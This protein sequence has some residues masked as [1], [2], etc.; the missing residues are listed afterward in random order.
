MTHDDAFL[1]AIIENPEDD[2]PRLVYADWLED[3]G[4]SDRADFIRLQCELARLPGGDPRRK[5]LEARERA[6]LKGHELEWLGPLRG[7]A[8]KWQFRRGFVESVKLGAEEFVDH[9]E[10]ILA[11]APVRHAEFRQGWYDSATVLARLGTCPHLTRLKSIRLSFGV[12]EVSDPGLRALASSPPLLNRLDRLFAMECNVT[13]AG[14]GPVLL[15]PHLGRLRGL[16]LSECR[17]HGAAGVLP[18]ADSPQLGRLTA[19][20]LDENRLGDEGV[21]LLAASRNC[22]RLEFL[23]LEECGVGDGGAEALG[24]SPH[25]GRLVELHLRDNR[26]GN[27]GASALAKS[28]HLAGLEYLHLHENRIGDAGAGALAA[29]PN[30]GRVQN[31]T[32]WGNRISQAGEEPL[33]V[34]FGGRVHVRR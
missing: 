28:P 19:L 16:H 3:H 7:R 32:L 5:G 17:L 12:C 24:R 23:S 20:S 18:L 30:L 29:S 25:L 26:V 14:L 22:S 9:A 1:Q 13:E 2:G 4:E 6:L 10:A 15:S 31:L 33:K 27:R 11:A 21:Q 34:R 8:D